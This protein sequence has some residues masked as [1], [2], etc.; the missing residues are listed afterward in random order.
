MVGLRTGRHVKRKPTPQGKI[1]Q[2]AAVDSAAI[3]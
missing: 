2:I 3:F 1:K